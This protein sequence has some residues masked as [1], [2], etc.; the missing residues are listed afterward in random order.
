MTVTS[1]VITAPQRKRVRAWFGDTPIADYLV[2]SDLAERYAAATLRRF[3]LRTTIDPVSAWE[4]SNDTE[5][6]TPLWQQ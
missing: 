3:G 5:A 6:R 4:E 2:A 1:T